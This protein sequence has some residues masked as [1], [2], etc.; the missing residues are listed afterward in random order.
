M[1]LHQTQKLG[2]IDEGFFNAHQLIVKIVL[3]LLTG[4]CVSRTESAHQCPPLGTMSK[5]IDLTRQGDRSLVSL[6]LK[7][8]P[9]AIKSD[10]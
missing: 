8:R 5:S 4:S 9:A 7:N 10:L 3:G 2:W 6:S 1:E